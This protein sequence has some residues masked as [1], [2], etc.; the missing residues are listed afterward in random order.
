MNYHYRHQLTDKN[1]G[2]IKEFLQRKKVICQT[3]KERI[4][5]ISGLQIAA[6][7]REIRSHRLGALDLKE[8]TAKDY[9]DHGYRLKRYDG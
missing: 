8:K 5:L 9:I 6:G 1:Q 7:K 4:D 2:F 3:Y